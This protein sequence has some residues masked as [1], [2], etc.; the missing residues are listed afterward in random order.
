MDDEIITDDTI[1]DDIVSGGGGG[2]DDTVNDDIQQGDTFDWD[3][4]YRDYANANIYKPE[5]SPTEQD[6][7]DYIERGTSSN[8]FLTNV[9]KQLGDAGKAFVKKFLYDE[10][11]GKINLAGMAT[12]ATA[13]YS[14]FGGGD[15]LKTAGYDVPVPL[16][17]ATRQRVDYTDPN[18]VP[19]SMGRQYFT[20]MQY[21][22]Q[23]NTDAIAAAKTAA[24]TQKQGLLSAYKP[25]AAPAVNPYVGRMPILYENPPFMYGTSPIVP[26]A[27]AGAGGAGGAGGA[28]AAT[29]TMA[30]GGI[31]NLAQG[32][33]LRGGTDGMADKINTS[34]D[35]KQP[36]KLSHGEFVIPAD[37]VSHLGNGNSDAGA[38][39]LYQMMARIRKARTG[40]A[41]QGKKINP[42]TFTAMGGGIATG[43]FGGGK[44]AFPDGGAVGTSTS[45]SLSPWAGPYVSDILA[46]G[47]AV[48]NQPFQAYT[49]PLTAG[50]SNLQQQQFAGLSDIA[51]TG[52]TPTSAS[53]AGLGAAGQQSYMNPYQQGVTNIEKRE[54]Q[55]AA[56]IATAQRGAKAAEK[57]AFGGS[58]QAIGDVGAA[59]GLATQLGDIQARGS[60]AAYTSGLDQFNKEQAA[61]EA[62]RQYSSKFGLESLGALGT[63]GATQQGITQAGM[64]AD[65]K[66][67]EEQRDYPAK[68]VQYQRD[69]ITGLPM[70]TQ[71]TT[72]NMTG[73]DQLTGTVSGLS[74]LYDKLKALIPEVK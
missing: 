26:A 5:N 25:V 58:R 59:S 38:A 62:S 3:S 44:V 51:G 15:K 65:Q 73:V 61:K 55:K 29:K 42:D 7:K 19:G 16:Y 36:A 8:P 14:I 67:F 21:N 53:F 10:A 30:H 18:R 49:G 39:K 28:A 40:N 60:Q 41:K 20:D 31:T 52:Y 50:P 12:A 45:S 71:A 46:K 63:A 4:F 48:S 74:S 13:L 70:S 54:A 17:D 47:A 33:Y 69:L 24:E 22:P 37:V 57:G 11:T 43:Y 64:T 35:N 66:A 72:Q 27:G 23:T 32:T 9:T 6:V 34:I 56:D 68:M 1:N 2:G